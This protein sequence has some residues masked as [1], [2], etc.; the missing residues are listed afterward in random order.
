MNSRQRTSTY[1]GV[2][3]W[4]ALLGARAQASEDNASQQIRQGGVAVEWTFQQEAPGNGLARVV[5]RDE[6]TGKPIE[7]VRPAAWLLARRSEQVSAEQSCEDKAR[8]MVGG[9]L[10][11]RADIDLNSYR[12][13]TLNN[14]NSVAFIN[15]YVGLRNSRLEAIVQLPSAGYDWVLASQVHRL[16]VSLRD[17]DAVAVIDTQQRRLVATV[18]MG[19]GSHPTRLAYDPGY[20]RI[21]VGLD[22]QARIVAL[23]AQ[24]A[25]KA[26]DLEVGMGLHTLALDTAADEVLVTHASSNDVSL[27]DRR[28]LAIRRVAVPDTPVAAAWS[29]AAG[30]WAVLSINGASLS[31]IEP[32]R[33]RVTRQTPLTRGV[34]KLVAFD[35]GRRLLALDPLHGTLSLIDAASA[36]VIV[37]VEL[38]GHPDQISLS[39]DFVYLRNRDD[40]NVQLIALARLR[41]G[42]MPIV[43]V[44]MGR[45]APG[46]DPDVV[47]VANVIAPAPEANGVLLANPGDATIYQYVEGMMVPI[48][49]F[50]NYRRKARGLMV[51]DGSLTDRGDGVFEAPL[52]AERGGRY[53]VVIRNQLPAVTACFVQ[54]IEGMPAQAQAQAQFPMVELVSGS[55]LLDGR[56]QVVF[57]LR[58]A[59]GARLLANDVQVLA[60]KPRT[61][62]QQRRTAIRR[63]DGSY[64]TTFS[65]VPLQGD[66][67]LFARVAV[68][69]MDYVDGKLGVVAAGPSGSGPSR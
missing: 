13:L 20:R 65:G 11:S 24:D 2:G 47:N 15:P 67:L 41:E 30:Q 29:V 38:D 35:A 22:G 19:T 10:G 46:E 36:R 57:R 40:A 52:Q 50:T 28:T 25:S 27:I 61:A 23:D 32:A 43:N 6:A 4:C 42:R 37:S 54:T 66:V 53:D 31:W 16:F 68:D 8:L 34:E 60:F 21:W 7:G 26:A 33:A 49:S 5:L 55:R 9:A 51:M 1:L 56:M 63:T 39:R 58:T 64:D 18:P 69:G 12:L 17:A 14:D 48:G 45:H 3:L 59:E 62:W 44:P